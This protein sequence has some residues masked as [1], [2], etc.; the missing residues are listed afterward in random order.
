[1]IVVAIIGILAAVAV[2]A[3]IKYVRRSKTTEA[4]MNVRKLYDSSVSYYAFDHH[5]RTGATLL[6]QF[7]DTVAATPAV[8]GCCGQSGDKCPPNPAQWDTATWRS[9]NFSVDDPHNY[10]YTYESANP[11]ANAQFTARASAN[12]DCDAIY[13]TF[14]RVGIID[15]S[16]NVVSGAGGVFVGN[17]IE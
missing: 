3:F 14:E 8:N 16:R 1:M 7:P 5:S 13:S 10:W 12:L 11:G 9:L 15:A 17:P 6:R 4:T 2:P